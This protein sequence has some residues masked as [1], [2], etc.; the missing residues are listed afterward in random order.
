MMALKVVG[1]I[2]GVCLTGFVVL[3]IVVSNHPGPHEY[4]FKERLRSGLKD[5]GSADIRAGRLHQHGLAYSYC[6]EVNAK[7][8]FG[9]YVGFRRFIVGD[10][11]MVEEATPTATFLDLWAH[12]CVG[13]Q[14]LDEMP[15][16]VRT[17]ARP[18]VALP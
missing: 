12:L 9:G 3:M 1:A 11:A 5:P 13:T 16:A 17:L 15:E 2:I 14:R 10:V 7:N 4:D 18:L 8:S 6:G